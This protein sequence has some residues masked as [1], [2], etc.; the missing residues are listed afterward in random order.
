MVLKNIVEVNEEKPL[1]RLF[2]LKNS[3]YQSVEVVEVEDIDF[4]EIK[5]HLEQGESVFISHKRQQKLNLS[6]RK[7]AAEPWFFSHL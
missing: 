3:E 5:K 6:A 2:F 1:F 4:R 7:D